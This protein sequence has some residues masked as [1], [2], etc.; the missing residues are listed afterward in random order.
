[1]RQ[2][3]VEAWIAAN[4]GPGAV[5]YNSSKERIKNPARTMTRADGSDNPN[6]DPTAPEWI[7]VSQESWTNTKSGAVLKASR[8][9]DGAYDVIENKQADPNKP[10]ASND[11][12]PG[13]K[14]FIDED[15]PSGRRMG[16]NPATKSYDRDLGSSP[17]AQAAAAVP[18]K[19]EVNPSDPTRLRKPDGKGG[20]TDAGPNAAG[21]RQQ[22]ADDQAVA[23]ANRPDTKPVEVKGSDG[24]T[25][26]RVTSVDK[27]G[28]VTIKN[29]GP[30]GKQVAEIPGEGPS[31]PTV[32]GP[33]LPEF[34]LGQSQQALSTYHRQLAEGVAAGRWSQAWADARFNEAERIANVAVTEAAT[35]QRNEESARNAGITVATQKQNAMA[36]AT[37]NAL[38][39]VNSINGLLPAGSP[40]GGQAF[41]ALLGLQM[42]Q[43]NMSG[44]NNVNTAAAPTLTPAEISNTNALDARRTQ[45]MANPV[46]RPAPIATLPAAAPPASTTPNQREGRGMPGQ[47]APPVAPVAPAPPVYEQ[48]RDTD[49]RG[50]GGVDESVVNP[51]P[52]PGQDPTVWTPPGAASV[53]PAEQVAAQPE[54]TPS[55]PMV[56]GAAE[57]AAD[58]Y[59]KLRNRMTGEVRLV[60]NAQHARERADWGILGVAYDA[61]WEGLPINTPDTPI[62]D[63]TSEPPRQVY[64]Q[65]DSPLPQPGGAPSPFSSASGNVQMAPSSPPQQEWAALAA[66]V[67]PSPSPTPMQPQQQAPQATTGEPV[68]MRRARIASTPPWRLDPADIEWADANGFGNEAWSVPGRAVA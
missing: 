68:A 34:V 49:G 23:A 44:I 54:A 9:P 41:A 48:A 10:A 14:P 20:W 6:Y 42:L 13:G 55:P 7:D 66:Y 28:T 64:T 16:W 62:S 21:I 8:R 59:V 50:Q 37:N 22:A 36:T 39:F 61:V 3:E 26:T 65:D 30:D 4:G 53:Q 58:G 60:S 32:A 19:E 29:F 15:G 40:L 2:D 17:Q 12:P 5:Q 27:D 56:P 63:P 43:A 52:V 67:P 11:G 25:Y 1:M 33:K 51:G 57:M 47:T 24:R 18:P 31:R 35:R 38:S 46:F 45:I